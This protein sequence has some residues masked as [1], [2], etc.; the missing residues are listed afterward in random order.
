MSKKKQTYFQDSWL[1]NEN[2]ELWLRKIPNKNTFARCRLCEKDFDLSNMGE[3]ALKSHAKG[4]GHIQKEKTALAV[5]N[6]FKKKPTSNTSNV[7]QQDNKQQQSTSNPTTSNTSNEQQQD[8][9]QPSSSNSVT[10]NTLHEQ[11]QTLDYLVSSN[12]TFKAEITFLIFSITKGHSWNSF[13]GL[14]QTLQDMFSDSQTAQNFQLSKDK[15]RYLTNFGLAPYVRE[16]L[17]SSLAKSPQV[18]SSFDESLNEKTQTSQMDLQIRFFDVEDD[19]VKVRYLDSK[20]LGHTA[21][22]DLLKA[23]LAGLEK[24]D[25]STILQISMDGPNVNWLF[26]EKYLEH[27]KEVLGQFN[28]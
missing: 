27:R 23:F 13:V 21:N 11:Q 28:F 20:F 12:K 4:K 17:L 16:E 26:Y 5:K 2:Y 19:T 22:T 10:T 15:A 7:K 6:Y 1:S 3:K 14:N 8:N 24:I 18:V 25:H 9:E